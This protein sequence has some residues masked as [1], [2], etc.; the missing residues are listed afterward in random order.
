MAQAQNKAHKA[1]HSSRTD[2]KSTGGRHSQKL[3]F[4]RTSMRQNRGPQTGGTIEGLIMATEAELEEA[5]EIQEF[6]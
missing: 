1:V 5:R 4:I 3:Q 2:R 6:E